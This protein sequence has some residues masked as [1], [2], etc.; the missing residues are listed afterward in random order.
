VGIYIGNGDVI[1]APYAGVDVRVDSIASIGGYVGATHP[2]ETQSATAQATAATTTSATAVVQGGLSNNQL[3]AEAVSDATFGVGQFAYLDELWDRESGWN[4][5]AT[6][7]S[8]GAFGIPQALPATKMA[9]AGA[10]YATDPYTQ[11]VWGETYIQRVYG[12]PQAAWAHEV[13]Y[14]WY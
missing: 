9:T 10:D 2:A 13:A 3:F 7:P 4:P 1:D 12:T 6:N 11:I 5:G 8:S 14:G